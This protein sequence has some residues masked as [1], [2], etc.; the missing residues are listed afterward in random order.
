[1]KL[2]LVNWTMR[3]AKQLSPEHHM[4]N[5]I[6]GSSP[7]NSNPLRVLEGE[8]GEPSWE[9]IPAANVHKIQLTE[10]NPIASPPSEPAEERKPGTASYLLADTQATPFSP[11][12]GQASPM[13]PLLK[14]IVE[15][16][17]YTAPAD[18]DRAINL[19]WVLR[20]ISTKPHSSIS[21]TRS[22]PASPS[23]RKSDRVA[24][25]SSI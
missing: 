6:E 12:D 15:P 21:S 18:R 11:A 13:S 25:T 3:A 10:G 5:D 14:A 20:D 19:R 23:P 8:R 2:D 9:G 7:L 1:M 4:H 24:R 16:D 22:A 17:I